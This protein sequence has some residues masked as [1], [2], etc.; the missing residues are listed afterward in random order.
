ML[1]LPLTNI[2]GFEFSFA[3]SVLLTFAGNCFA[4]SSSKRKFQ[5]KEIAV[6]SI[7]IVFL[8]LLLGMVNGLFIRNCS[9]FD[10][11][12]F[13]FVFV[14]VSFIF[15]FSVG[16]FFSLI[17]VYR[18]CVFSFFCLL[19]I[20]F[21][22]VG[23]YYYS[24]Q[25]YLF[26]PVFCFFPGLIYD[27]EI[28]L[29][30]NIIYYRLII[31]FISGLLIYLVN[32]LKIKREIRFCLDRKFNL[33]FLL[34]F[35]TVFFGFYF[36]DELNFST[37]YKKLEKHFG[38]VVTE[39]NFSI[40]YNPIKEDSLNESL[41]LLKTNVII[42]EVEDFFQIK[43]VKHIK[44]FVFNSNEEKKRLL[45][46]SSYGFTKP[47]QGTIFLSRGNFDDVMKH[48][49]SHIIA[50]EFSDNMF[51]VAGNINAG[52]IEGSAM[53]SEWN[54]LERTP[55]QLTANYNYFIDS[56]KI[57][58]Y[59]SGINFALQ[60]SSVSYIISGSFCR[61]LIDK[62]GIEKFKMLYRENDFELVYNKD[63]KTIS[64]EFIQ[65]LGQISID[66][67]DSL[68]STFLFKS[69]TVFQKLCVRYLAKE[70]NKIN[71]MIRN[72]DYQKALNNVN[73]LWADYKNP[74]VAAAIVLTKI[75]LGKANESIE[76]F[77]KE[78]DK[79]KLKISFLNFYYYLLLASAKEKN[80]EY[81]NLFLNLVRKLNYSEKFNSN[82]ELIYLIRN[83]TV[84]TDI[85]L[86]GTDRKEF[87]EKLNVE[88][89]LEKIVKKRFF[90]YLNQRD[91]SELIDKTEIS[92][93]TEFFR[94]IFFFCLSLKDYYNCNKI[95]IKFEKK[96]LNEIQ[97][98]TYKYLQGII[99]YKK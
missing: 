36:S 7:I 28:K 82:I 37:S 33:I 67:N 1:R 29:T 78:F 50:G 99:N 48:E 26:N 55:H 58:R 60:N 92:G 62:Y 84:L 63:I 9:L 22:S 66:K 90:I 41:Y 43:Q 71:T 2:L 86:K 20:I 57:E 56:L 15:G 27:E 68:L 31:L 89:P 87:F 69:E 73:L 4:I 74:R 34:F 97:K 52:L 79:E 16:H 64:K 12:L 96:E 91:R 21:Y 72:K 49:I 76:F 10:G 18:K 61:F 80:D 47:W 59:F 45:G 38:K 23:I 51:K 70:M 3:N 95:I 44:I 8:P 11:I 65:F 24:P 54:Y 30:E 25:L 75:M 42:K 14:P 53:A 98:E 85:F 93:E 19:I 88:F 32:L 17:K 94:E 46:S 77:N 5:R 35:L 13:Y 81:F 39:N 40:Y 83:D 6:L